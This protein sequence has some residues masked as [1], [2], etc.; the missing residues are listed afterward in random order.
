MVA[1]SHNS[2]ILLSG[3]GSDWSLGMKVLSILLVAFTLPFCS[4]DDSSG[5]SAV[6]DPAPGRHSIRYEIGGNVG[7]NTVRMEYI[8]SSGSLVA[9][10]VTL[11]TT[12]S[13][14]RSGGDL[15]SL[16]GIFRPETGR[17]GT[18][19]VTIKV[20]NKIWKTNSGSGNDIN[21]AVSGNL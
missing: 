11:P 9:E 6:F 13:A 12:R 14:T 17:S 16:R 20:D 4:D 2:A 19:S 18:I 15:V 10:A 7:E 5:G 8:N 1:I 3:A 21:V